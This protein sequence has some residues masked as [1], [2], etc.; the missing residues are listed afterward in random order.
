MVYRELGSTG[1]RVS[2][3]GMGCEGFVEKSEEQVKEFI[4]LME[5][6]GVNCIDLYSPNPQMRSALGAALRGRR[7]KFVLQ[8][9]LCTIWKDGQY[10]RTRDIGEVKEG[11]ADQLERLETG[12]VEIGMIHYVDSVAEWEKIENGPILKYAL[13]LKKD[14]IIKSIGMSSHNPQAAMAAV[15][16]GRVD[17]LMFSVNPCYDLIPASED[18]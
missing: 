4:D 16:S 15:K 9:H 12:Y 1:I 17:V 10:K 14:G 5:E 3:I 18:V 6:E 11:F 7:D 8:A 2:E 13:E